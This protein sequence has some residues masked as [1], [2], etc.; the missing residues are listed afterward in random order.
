MTERT[1][2]LWREWQRPLEVT[3]CAAVGT[4]YRRLVGGLCHEVGSGVLAVTRGGPGL[5]G[6]LLL[7]CGGSEPPHVDDQLDT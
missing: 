3:G 2:Q 5:L 1:G 4:A 6:G 7:L